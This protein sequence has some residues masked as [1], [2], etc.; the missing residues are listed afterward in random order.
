[1]LWSKS[2]IDTDSDCPAQSL[3]LRL[4]E[5]GGRW[6]GYT[7]G[8]Y[9]HD[10]IHASCTDREQPTMDHMSVTEIAAASKMMTNFSDMET[11]LPSGTVYEKSFIFEV[12]DAGE[13]VSFGDAPEWAIRGEGWDPTQ[14]KGETLFRMQP[15]AYFVEPDGTVVIYDWKTGWG[16][17]SDSS[18]EKD[19][20]AITYAAALSLVY[21]DAP[22]VKFIWW[23]IRYK[24]GQM[25][26]RTRSEW[27][28]LAAPFFAGCFAK[29][30]HSEAEVLN[31]ARA[32]EHCG[33]CPY[34]GSCLVPSDEDKM[35]DGDLYRYS[36]RI[37]ELSRSVKTK[38]T[39]RMKERTGVLELGGGVR[40]GPT[41]KTGHRWTKGGKNKGLEAS[42]DMLADLG[43]NPYDYF[44]IKGSV[45]TWLEA[46]PDDVRE[47]VEPHLVETNRQT[48]VE[49]E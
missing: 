25:I 18:L 21:P 41:N 45:S 32:G 14:A 6:N 11:P 29:D 7:V 23:N 8:S 38:M 12:S 47:V 15:D 30:R 9:V 1:M 35:D 37:A 2:L 4:G 5:A 13:L 22:S 10:A 43:H 27:S 16:L 17:P 19:I 40:L 33:R 48:F 28:V 31:D 39:A 34:K 36:R 44:D 24:K 42:Y 49:K 26:Q 3:K 46:L 20:Q